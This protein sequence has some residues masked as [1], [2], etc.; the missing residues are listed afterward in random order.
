MWF[1]YEL[2]KQLN[3]FYYLQLELILLLTTT[4]HNENKSCI[5]VLLNHC[6]IILS[7]KDKKK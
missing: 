2:T 3:V 4:L 5:C 7:L 6:F 1:I